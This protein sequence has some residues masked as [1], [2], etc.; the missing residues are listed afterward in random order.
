MFY[1]NQTTSRLINNKGV[2]KVMVVF[3]SFAD[4]PYQLMRIVF[5]RYPQLIVQPAYLRSHALPP[6]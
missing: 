3:V 5:Q 2:I 6:V 4:K 1:I